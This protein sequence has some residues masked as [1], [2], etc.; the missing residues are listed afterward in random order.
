[1]PAPAAR[2]VPAA[3]PLAIVRDPRQAAT[4]VH[5]ER[6]RL[7]EALSEPHSASALGRRFNLPRQRLNYHLRA[8]ERA[9]LVE[10]VEERRKGNCIERVVRATARAYVLSP[11]VLGTL[12]R[13]GEEARDRMSASWL[14]SVA[15]RMIR[16]VASLVSRAQAA[17]KRVA[18]LTLESDIRFASAEDRARFAEE[19]TADIG[20]LAAKYHDEHAAGGR[21][22]RLVAAVYPRPADKEQPR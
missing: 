6:A 9:R 12:G 17:R 5:P 13:T 21:R 15:A 16:E 2:P 14:L 8:L 22:F 4:L 3:T 1:M 10:L 7:L 18:T 20:R 19:L 11:D